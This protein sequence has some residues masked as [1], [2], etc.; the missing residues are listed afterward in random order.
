M[1]GS[2]GKGRRGTQGT[3]RSPGDDLGGADEVSHIPFL[4]VYLGFPGAEPEHVCT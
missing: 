1:P 3:F 2:V 4:H